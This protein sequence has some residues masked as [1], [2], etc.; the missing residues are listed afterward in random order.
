M[1]LIPRE[2]ETKQ[3]Y[4]ERLGGEEKLLRKFQ[5]NTERVNQELATIYERTIK[6]IEHA[7]SREIARG[8]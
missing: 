8:V 7:T 1:E 5:E 6:E 2:G 4:I 3:Q